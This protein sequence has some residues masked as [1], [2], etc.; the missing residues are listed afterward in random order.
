[1]GDLAWK[2]RGLF[3][4][5]EEA[6]RH[7]AV[8]MGSTGSGKSVTL[9]RCAY[10]AHKVYHRQV[11]YLDAKGETK[12]EDE[13]SQDNAAHFVAAMHAAG[14]NN[15]LVF[16]SLS[17]NG[18]QGTP[19]E[20]K[21]RLLSVIDYSESPYY[22]DVAA[23]VLDLA[24]GTPTTP[25]SSTHFLANL[26]LDRLKAI[27]KDNPLQYRRVLALDKHL[28]E[29]VEMRYQVFFAAVS[30][31][32]DG[33]L[34]YSSADAVYLRVR[35]FTLRAEAPRLGRFLIF[36]AP[37]PAI[38]IRTKLQQTTP[39]QSNLRDPVAKN[40]ANLLPATTRN[41]P[42]RQHLQWH[43]HRQHRHLYQI[44][45]TTNPIGCNLVVYLAFL[46]GLLLP[47]SSAP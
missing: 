12:R 46:V 26:R 11:I 28:L 31:Q 3:T 27:Y 39:E 9:L 13:M 40:A 45:T 5:P 16:P 33:T 2:K 22:G 6:L 14:A 36:D 17:Y 44:P 38:Q 4:L 41:R 1:M 15:V 34:D 21:N 19:A 43:H 30:E 42:N 10:G 20:L 29:Q 37:P 23:N 24:L 47:V 25:R 35:G 32:L 8:V 18:W 7:H